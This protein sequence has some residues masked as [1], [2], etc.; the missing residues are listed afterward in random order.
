MA[1][2]R[3]KK[4]SLFSKIKTALQNRANKKDTEYSKRML[5]KVTNHCILMMWGTYVL[6]WCGRAEIAESLSKTIATAIIGIIVPYFAK[7]LFENLSK[8][9][10]FGN[11][12]SVKASFDEDEEGRYKKIQ[13]DINRYRDC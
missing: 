2:K 10:A 12:K 9:N 11:K 4:V 7:S 8:H 5:T 1:K 13:E 3:K 6:A